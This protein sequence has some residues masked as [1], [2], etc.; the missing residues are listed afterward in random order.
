V[1]AHAPVFPINCRLFDVGRERNGS[2]HA[3]RSGLRY[4]V[5]SSTAAV[6]R[7]EDGARVVEGGYSLRAVPGGVAAIDGCDG[8]VGRHEIVAMVVVGLV[9]GACAD[10]EEV[11][12]VAVGGDGGWSARAAGCALQLKGAS[13][14]F[15]ELWLQEDVPVGV[16]F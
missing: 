12:G 8:G 9:V 15:L 11:P 2:K 5:P 1:C 10:P 14:E 16:I 6:A 4:G 3:A 13:C 7:A